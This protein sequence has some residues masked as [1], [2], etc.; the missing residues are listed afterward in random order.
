VNGMITPFK[1]LAKITDLRVAVVAWRDTIISPRVLDLIELQSSVLTPGFSK[2]GLQ[3]TSPAAATIVVRFI[4]M[5][6]NEILFT[7]N[8]LDDKP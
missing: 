3:T 7:H 5:H 6:V 1:M 2:T 8:R 4:R